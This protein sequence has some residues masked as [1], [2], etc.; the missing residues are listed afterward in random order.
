[1]RILSLDLSTKS[2][3]VA[4]LETTNSSKINLVKYECICASSTDVLQRIKKICEGIKNFTEKEKFDHVIF[5]EVRPES[6]YGAKNQHTQRVLSWLQG[7]VA[8]IIHDYID[9]KMK[10]EFIYPNEWRAACGIHTGAG[11]KRASLKPADIDF[12]KKTYKIEVNDDIADAI[13]VGYGWI[14][15]NLKK[16]DEINWE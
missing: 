7:E 3:G 16:E 10:F 2:S 15:K 5:E 12:V 11:V 1:M 4:I 9:K 6:K 8:M 14:K 13:G